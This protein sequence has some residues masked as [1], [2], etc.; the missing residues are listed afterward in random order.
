MLGKLVQTQEISAKTTQLDMSDLDK[1]V[2]LLK[3]GNTIK[4]VIKE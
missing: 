3:I 2:Y 4:R 1:G